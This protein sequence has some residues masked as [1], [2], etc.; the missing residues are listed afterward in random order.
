MDTFTDDIEIENDPGT[1]QGSS[2][3]SIDMA[4]GLVAIGC[5]NGTVEIWDCITG[6]IKCQ[7][8]D[9]RCN[10]ASHLKMLPGRVVVARV[11]GHLDFLDIVSVASEGDTVVCPPVSRMRLVST[12][13]S[14]SLTNYGDE[15]RLSWTSGCRAHLQ[16]I[17][18]LCVQGRRLITGSTDHTLRVFRA[19]DGVGVYTLHGHSGPITCIFID[20]HSPLTAGSASQDGML[21]VWDLL[22]GACMYSVQAH[23]GPVT[24]IT[25]S[26]GCVVTLG[27]D[28]K[29][30][31]W[32]RNQGHLLNCVDTSGDCLSGL[33]MLTHNIIVTASG[34]S[35]VVW[36][37]RL[38]QPV[39]IVR[40]G[41]VQ[42]Q[43]RVNIIR[44]SGDTLICSCDNQIKLVKFP[45]LT[46]KID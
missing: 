5:D 10:G 35:L 22:T 44:Q 38:S 13:S 15:M 40:L 14:D 3:W 26:P 6:L 33:V 7:Y 23:V 21:C 2:V 16:S 24:E 18:V 31:V 39:K 36:D 27:Q 19:D 12:D 42:S 11:D 32:E 20:R 9:S 34:S 25:Y 17:S 29:L 37:V 41:S 1:L 4:D 8:D 30:C 45:I 43:A 46:Q 28:D